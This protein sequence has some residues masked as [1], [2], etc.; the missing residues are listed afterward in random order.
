MTD[1]KNK[2]GLEYTLATALPFDP[3]RDPL[4]RFKLICKNAPNVQFM[5]IELAQYQS[6]DAKP[7]YEEVVLFGTEAGGYIAAHAWHSNVAGEE[8]FWTVAEVTTIKEAMD[9]WGWTPVAKAFARRL[10][11][12]STLY[13]G[14][15]A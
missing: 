11:W 8:S 9:V 14:I 13:L 7:R 3:A 6:S 1:N 5:G 10:G 4:E 12:D 15:A 2:P